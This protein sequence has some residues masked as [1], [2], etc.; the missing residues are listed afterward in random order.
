MHNHY[1]LWVLKQLTPVTWSSSSGI[2]KI[3]VLLP[4]HTLFRCS[5]LAQFR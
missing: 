4:S 3:Q 5:H 1:N 2:D